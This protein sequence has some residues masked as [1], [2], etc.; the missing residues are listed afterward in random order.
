MPRLSL[1]SVTVA[2][3]H[4]N[5]PFP[6]CLVPLFQSESWCIAFHVNISFHSHA[7]KTPFHLEGFA[8][9]LALKKG[10]RQLG[11]GLLQLSS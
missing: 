4:C 3:M 9:G 1:S 5:R 7:D 6:N 10:T 11:N 8:R 2:H